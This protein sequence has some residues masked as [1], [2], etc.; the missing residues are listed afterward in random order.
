M[1]YSLVN[2]IGGAFIGIGKAFISILTTTIFYFMIT[3]LSTFNSK[4]ISPV[5]PT[6]VTKT[7]KI[8]ILKKLKKFI[9]LRLSLYAHMESQF[10]S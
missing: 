4:I 10:Y 8:H 7:K 9:L 1:R 6:I 3:R 5:L 2:G